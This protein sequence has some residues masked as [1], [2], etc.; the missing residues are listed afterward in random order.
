M[1]P[2]LRGQ[3]SLP[4]PWLGWIE[5]DPG[6]NLHSI[7][8]LNWKKGP[9]YGTSRLLT[10]HLQPRHKITPSSHTTPKALPFESLV[11][12]STGE[13]P[14]SHHVRSFCGASGVPF[15]WHA[16]SGLRAAVE[17]IRWWLW[18]GSFSLDNLTGLLWEYSGYER[19][20]LALQ[21]LNG[22]TSLKVWSQLRNTLKQDGARF[23]LCCLA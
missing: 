6:S 16:G 8:K 4:V 17:S 1:Y 7:I 18:A 15:C 3:V 23:R 22:R 9:K 5:E 21:F 10:A 13:L 12:L 19:S 14:R 2:I 20:M 11:P